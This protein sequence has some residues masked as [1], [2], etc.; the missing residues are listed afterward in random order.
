M[1]MEFDNL[2]IEGDR[3]D[4][5]VIVRVCREHARNALDRA[6]MEELDLAL[7]QIAIEGNAECLILTAAGNQ[8]FIAGGDLKDFV[9]LE[10]PEEGAAMARRMGE[11][12]QRL[13]DLAI[14]SIAAIGAN[15]YGGGCEVALACDLRVMAEGAHLVFSQARM[16]L[17]TG[18]GGTA[19]LVRTV[20]AGH[21]TRILMTGQYVGAE[22]AVAIGLAAAS[23]P[24]GHALSHALDLARQITRHPTGSIQAFKALIRVAAEG[25]VAET[26]ALENRL[27]ASR[28]GSPEHQSAVAAFLARRP[29]AFSKDS[30]ED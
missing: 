28:W 3:A 16:G 14:P 10:S 27:F 26:M 6:T 24:E 22:E 4:G 9:A 12:L 17:I 15:A 5:A 19:R 29:P 8:A 20:G 7:Q 25:P 11:V 2:E 30:P 1:S 18:W 23:A 13:E 21:A